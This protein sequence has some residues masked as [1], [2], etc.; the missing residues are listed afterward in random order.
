MC[1]IV[2]DLLTKRDAVALK[3]YEQSRLDSYIE[4]NNHVHWCP[5]V[6][7]CGRAV[8]MLDDE[9]CEP[10][11]PCGKHFCFKC[12]LDPHSPC[13]CEMWAAW[14]EKE[15]GDTETKHWLQARTPHACTLCQCM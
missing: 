3:K 12:N 14:K 9:Y 6:P 7:N 13:T 1:S 11:C 10:S 5:S 8:Q 4:D 2:S 15:E